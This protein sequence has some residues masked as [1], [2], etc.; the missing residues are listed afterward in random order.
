MSLIQHLKPQ[1]LKD[2]TFISPIPNGI[3][4]HKKGESSRVLRQKQNCD[5]A[6]SRLSITNEG[7]TKDENINNDTSKVILFTKLI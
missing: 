7:I 3:F 2:I 1:L 4:S 5:M 6:I